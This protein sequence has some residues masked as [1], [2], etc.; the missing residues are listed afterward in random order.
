VRLFLQKRPIIS[1][2]LLT[3]ATPYVV[4]LPCCRT[5]SMDRVHL[6]FTECTYYMYTHIHCGTVCYSVVP[7]NATP[8]FSDTFAVPQE[9]K[10]DLESYIYSMRDRVVSGNLQDYMAQTD[11]DVFLPKLDEVPPTPL[12]LATPLPFPLSPSCHPTTHP[13]HFASPLSSPDFP[14]SNTCIREESEK[15]T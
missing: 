1:S 11:R 6:L 2:I 3:E 12:S 7:S 13:P 4:G 10:N 14:S 8:L 5:H 15:M 9:R